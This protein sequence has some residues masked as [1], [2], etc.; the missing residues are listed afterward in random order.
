MVMDKEAVDLSRVNVLFCVYTCIHRARF[1]DFFVFSFS[2][3]H[4]YVCA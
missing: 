4:C 3:N 1:I 2:L